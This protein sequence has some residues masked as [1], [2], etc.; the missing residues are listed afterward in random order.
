MSL[1]HT[2]ND[3]NQE[4]KVHFGLLTQRYFQRSRSNT[5]AS[6]S[7]TKMFFGGRPSAVGGLFS[8]ELTWRGRCS[9]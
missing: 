6:A 1:W 5:G 3:E 7:R 2:T 4:S 9:K 8:E